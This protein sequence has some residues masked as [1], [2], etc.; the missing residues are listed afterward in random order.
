MQATKWAR[1]RYKNSTSKIRSQFYQFK[2][3]F[4]SS[5]KIR[6]KGR[7]LMIRIRERITTTPRLMPLVAEKIQAKGKA[8][9]AR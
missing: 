6:K 9:I 1:I 7:G 3:F 8:I 5:A 4:V 2:Y